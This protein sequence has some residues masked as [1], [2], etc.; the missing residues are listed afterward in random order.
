[1]VTGAGG[2]VKEGVGTGV[3]IGTTMGVGSGVGAG[4]AVGTGVGEGVTG[5]AVTEAGRVVVRV[6][7]T[8][9][10]HPLSSVADSIRQVNKSSFFFIVRHS[11]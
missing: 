5:A 4:V 6:F 9:D 7:F 8:L 3:D 10:P 2:N 1:V 11:L